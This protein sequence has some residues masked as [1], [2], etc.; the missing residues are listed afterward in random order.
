VT[1][2]DVSPLLCS[3]HAGLPSAIVVTAG[4]DPLRDEGA[5]YAEKL[6]A[7][8]VKVSYRCEEDLAHGFFAMGSVSRSA[9]RATWRITDDLRAALALPGSNNA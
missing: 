5:R 6:A 1:H 9:G 4:F 7:A 3:D 2:P 8:G